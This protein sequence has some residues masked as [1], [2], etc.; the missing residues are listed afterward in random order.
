[1]SKKEKVK[2]IYNQGCPDWMLTFGDCMSLLLCFFVMLMTFSTP[3]ENKLLDVIGGL[4]GALGAVEPAIRDSQRISMTRP[5]GGEEVEGQVS[6]G[7]P[8]KSKVDPE[9]MSPISLREIKIRNRLASFNES[10]YKLGFKNVVTVQQLDEGVQIEIPLERLF[11]SGSD[12]MKP[13]ASKWMEPFAGLLDSIGNEARLTARI[14]RESS[15]SLA[16]KRLE[17]L[18]YALSSRY[19][20]KADRISMGLELTEGDGE[21]SLKALLAGNLRA[22]ELPMTEFFR[23]GGF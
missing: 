5:R 2:I 1:M 8:V 23:T 19:K 11:S 10:L 9:D 17:T 7:D 20:I 12:V 4:Q 16:R 18:S 15:V 14:A 21:E 22:R 6:N 3:D 13:G